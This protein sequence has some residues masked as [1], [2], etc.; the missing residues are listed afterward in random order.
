MK[1]GID[2][3]TKLEQASP[4]VKANLRSVLDAE[5]EK[6][7]REAYVQELD[8]VLTMYGKALRIKIRR[9]DGA[10]MFWRQVWEIFEEA[11]PN[12]WAFQVFPPFQEMMDEANIY[13]L[14]V[15]HSR[16]PESLNLNHQ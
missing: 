7:E 5:L 11:Y 2:M 16:M 3:R 4:E 10:P 9:Y 8:Y 1:A 14:F 13:H 6:E 15:L 12:C